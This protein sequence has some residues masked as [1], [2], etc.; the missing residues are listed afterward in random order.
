MKIL[1]ILIFVAILSFSAPAQAKKGTLEGII[2]FTNDTP[3]NLNTFPV[4]LYTSDQRRQV[5]AT[6]PNQY[7]GFKFEGIKRGKYVLRIRWAPN[8]RCILLYRVDFTEKLNISTGII[9]DAAC[10]AANAV[11]RKLPERD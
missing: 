8:D 7:G 6:K 4:E 3:R 10:S 1:L 2:Y 5:A 9:M 11:P